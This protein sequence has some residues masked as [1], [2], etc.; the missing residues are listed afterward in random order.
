MGGKEVPL[1]TDQDFYIVKA[2]FPPMRLKCD[3]QPPD[4]AQTYE[5]QTGRSWEVAEL[6]N[7]I[8]NICGVLEVGLFVGHTGPEALKIGPLGGQ[9]PTAVYFGMQDG[10]VKVRRN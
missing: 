10:T 8:K 6:A 9:K 5:G 1:K 2:P 4:N 3:L 7:E